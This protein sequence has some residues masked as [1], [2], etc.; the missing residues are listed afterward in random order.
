M[1][2]L[3]NKDIAQKL[4]I[5][6]AA[7]SLTIHNKPGVS[8][9]T[10][11]KIF[12]LIGKKETEAAEKNIE[13]EQERILLSI[14]KKTGRIIDGKAFFSDLIATIQQE[15][16][17]NGK[18]LIVSHFTPEMQL[19]EYFQYM[20]SMQCGGVIIIA[21]ELTAQDI[22]WYL[23]LNIPMAVLDNSVIL[24]GVDV[25]TLDTQVDMIK[26]VNYAYRKGHR[27]IGY[28]KS[29]TRISNFDQHMIGYE[30]GLKSHGLIKRE[31]SVFELPCCILE[32]YEKMKT[33]LEGLPKDYV[34]PTCFL[35]DLD[36]IAIGAMRAF[37]EA[38]YA[39]PEEVSFIGYDD[40][41]SCEACT[42]SLTTVRVKNRKMGQ[43][44]VRRLVKRMLRPDRTSLRIQI[45]SKFIERG[46]VADRNRV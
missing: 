19:S 24:D 18:T 7:V 26:C 6:E 44:A 36:Y 43:L 2:N 38:G 29:E 4:G 27:D 1:G 10:R 21:T 25:I 33:I 22:D 46:S 15:A 31:E 3:R 35:A 20:R 30:T 40:I 11:R 17:K 5:S 32:A 39:I 8:D 13:T 9:A 37:R 14:H 28:L 41:P 12:E 16:V 34:M 42:P 45:P 23:K